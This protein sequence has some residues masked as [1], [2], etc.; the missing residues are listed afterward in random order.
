M[1]RDNLGGAEPGELGLRLRIKNK[2]TLTGK[3]VA[4]D[5]SVRV[6]DQGRERS[7]RWKRSGQ[8]AAHSGGACTWGPP[9]VPL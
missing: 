4:S 3:N 1:N 8:Q 7:G 5:T 2:N 9:L 6:V